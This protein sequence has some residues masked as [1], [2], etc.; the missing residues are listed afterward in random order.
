LS[1]VR[2]LPSQDQQSFQSRA[3]LTVREERK[4]KEEEGQK[5]DEGT[6]EYYSLMMYE[7]D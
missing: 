7:E 1:F 5:Y 6:E 4:S 3:G 2:D